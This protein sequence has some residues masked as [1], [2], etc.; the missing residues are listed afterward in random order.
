MNKD[1][2]QVKRFIFARGTEP[3][4][5]MLIDHF[6]YFWGDIGIFI[7]RPLTT[8]FAFNTLYGLAVFFIQ[9]L[10]PDVT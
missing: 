4:K 8:L 6:K 1:M 2:R 5:V 10:L 7:V 9:C 3:T